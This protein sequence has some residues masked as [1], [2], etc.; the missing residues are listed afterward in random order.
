MPFW[1]CLMML[2]LVYEIIVFLP[3]QLPSLVF[4]STSYNNSLTEHCLY[5]LYIGGRVLCF[6][7][8][9]FDTFSNPVV[10]HGPSLHI[11]NKETSLI[12]S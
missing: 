10:L 8:M 6:C 1:F 9:I 2:L 12:V 3:L 5:F 7:H 4:D 11:H